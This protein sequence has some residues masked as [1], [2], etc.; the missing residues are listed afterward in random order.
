[1]MANHCLALAIADIGA[2]EFRRQLE[3]KALIKIARVVVANRWF[4]SSRRC[5]DCGHLHAGLTLADREL[6]G[7]GCGVVDDRDVNASLFS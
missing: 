2:F 1:M 6:I 7:D 5:S 3:Y 4:P